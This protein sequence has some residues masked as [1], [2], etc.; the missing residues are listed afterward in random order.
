MRVRGFYR[1]VFLAA[2]SVAAQSSLHA[3]QHVSEINDAYHFKYWQGSPYDAAY[4]EWWYFNL[5]DKKDDLQAIFTYQVADPLN[6]SRQGGGDMTMVVY[7]GDKTI[8][9]GDFYP[10]SLFKASYS[11]ANV[12]V[13]ANTISVA[14]PNTYVIAGSSLDGRLSWNLYYDRES[15]PW[16]GVHHKN[17]APLPWEQMSWLLY[18]PRARVSGTLTVD[19]HTYQIDCPGYHDHNWGEWDFATVTWNWAQFSE[20]GLS[21]DLGDFVGNPNGRASIDILGERIVFPADHYN[22]IHTKWALDKQ[23]NVSYPIESLFTAENKEVKDPH[24]YASP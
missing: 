16:F 20:P 15:G 24:H 7:Q 6:L 12:S 19:G 11:A 9:E 21:F 5:Y 13:G 10:L 22:L 2:L 17:V 3:Q 23:N 14:E 8:T 1:S 4:T 18:M